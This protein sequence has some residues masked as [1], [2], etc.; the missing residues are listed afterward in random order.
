MNFNGVKK[1]MLQKLKDEL[2]SHL[3]Y[4]NLSHVL[5]VIKVTEETAKSEGIKGDNLTL[6]RT[7]AL[8]HDS[9]FIEG[10]KNHEEVSCNIAQKI[11]PQFDYTQD[12][13]NIIK[14]IIMATKIPQTPHNHLEKIIG[15]ADLDY[16]GRDDFYSIGNGL[17][18]ELKHFGVITN[19][20]EWNL[21][22]KNFIEAHTYH[23]PTALTNRDQKKR[24]HL[25][26]IKAELEK[27]MN[28]L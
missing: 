18:E 24:K 19:K 5:D 2:P 11:L 21:I 1:M 10:P 4:H 7:A 14:G 8:F 6:L 26:A 9:G 20:T 17:F 13:I 12:Q 15:D 22:Q 25:E 16:L 23:T 28:K 27:L 3:T